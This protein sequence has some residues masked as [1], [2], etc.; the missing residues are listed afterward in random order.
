MS[1][2]FSLGVHEFI[3]L[4]N[5]LKVEGWCASGALA[6]QAIEAGQV[7]VDDCVETRKRCKIRPGQRVSFNGQTL[8]V[9]T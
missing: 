7:S 2:Q 3:T 4:S 6:K 1:E 8:V 5:L 9:T